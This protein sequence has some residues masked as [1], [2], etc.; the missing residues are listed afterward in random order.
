MI[1][2]RHRRI[3]YQ[4]LM[5]NALG[6]YGTSGMAYREGRL[7]INNWKQTSNIQKKQGAFRLQKETAGGMLP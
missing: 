5:L 3:L 6:A 7:H 2:C 1:L 4:P